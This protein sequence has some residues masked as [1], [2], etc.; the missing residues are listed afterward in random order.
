MPEPS[1]P[2]DPTVVTPPVADGPTLPAG[3][4]RPTGSGR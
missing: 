2:V 3:A 1:D 4:P